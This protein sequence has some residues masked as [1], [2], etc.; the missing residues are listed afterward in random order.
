VLLLL[1]CADRIVMS[2]RGKLADTIRYVAEGTFPLYLFHFPALV[3]VFAAL[4]DT[5]PSLGLRAAIV[6]ALCTLA[7]LLG[8]PCNMLKLRMRAWMLRAV[9][10]RDER[11]S[12][13]VAPP[14]REAETRVDR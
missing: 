3:L 10:R 11:V 4:G 5:N 1:L 14:Q 13:W 9:S 6:A 7:V 12:A 8:H 2:N